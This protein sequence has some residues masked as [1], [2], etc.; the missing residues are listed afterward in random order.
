LRV[1]IAATFP[2]S[3]GAAAYT[4]GARAGRRPGKTVLTVRNTA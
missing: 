4:S 2:L 1:T 3:E